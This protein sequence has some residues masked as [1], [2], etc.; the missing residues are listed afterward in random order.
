MRVTAISYLKCNN[1]SV[2]CAFLPAAVMTLTVSQPLRSLGA[3][4]SL[5]DAQAGHSRFTASS[6]QITIAVGSDQS[7]KASQIL[8]DSFPL[9][10]GD[11]ASSWQRLCHNYTASKPCPLCLPPWASDYLWAEG[12]ARFLHPIPFSFT[13]IIPHW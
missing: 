10:G 1:V 7:R 3:R 9:M 11:S 13:G 4:T 12:S 5:T 6:A 8:L 2:A